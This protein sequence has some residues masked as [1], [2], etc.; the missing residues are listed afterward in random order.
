[1]A[2]VCAPSCPRSM[3]EAGW[4]EAHP[5]I[6][7]S[8]VCVHKG[9]YV[10]YH[11]YNPHQILQDTVKCFWI[12]EGSYPTESKQDIT[13]DGCVELIFSFGSP[14]LLLTTNPP[15]PLATG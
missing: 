13:P 6:E 14:Y 15:T 12:H 1:M 2:P 9:R 8:I 5:S 10:K 4:R 11:E 3:D 7:L